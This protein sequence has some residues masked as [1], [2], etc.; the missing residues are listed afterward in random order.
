MMS[1]YDELFPRPRRR[2]QPILHEIS[3]RLDFVQPRLLLS[4]NV[5]NRLTP[6]TRTVAPYSSPYSSPTSSPTALTAFT[7]FTSS[8]CGSCC[9]LRRTPLSCGH[10]W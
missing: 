2:I 4:R 6:T 8:T 10:P 9:P 1:E 3:R 5:F 7:A